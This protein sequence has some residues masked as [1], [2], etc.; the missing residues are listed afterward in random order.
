MSGAM[1]MSV[2]F[3]LGLGVG[4]GLY[5][6]VVNLLPILGKQTWIVM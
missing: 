4:V 3:V 5:F 6:A 2:G 1:K